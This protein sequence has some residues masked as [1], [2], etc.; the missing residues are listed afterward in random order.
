MIAATGLLH[1]SCDVEPKT[2]LKANGS[3]SVEDC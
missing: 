3:W 2:K 1:M